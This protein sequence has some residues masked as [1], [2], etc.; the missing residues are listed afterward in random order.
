[1]KLLIMFLA[2]VGFAAA[3]ESWIKHLARCHNDNFALITEL[4]SEK[5]LK[6]KLTEFFNKIDILEEDP[7]Y[8]IYYRCG[9]VSSEHSIA[10]KDMVADFAKF[11]QIQGVKPSITE[12]IVYTE[13]MKDNYF[14]AKRIV[15]ELPRALREN[16]LLVY[17]QPKHNINS[18]KLAGGEALVRWNRHFK[19]FLFPDEMIEFEDLLK[20][21]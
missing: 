15:S 3:K 1:M 10:G 19:E 6:I 18:D 5:E 4:L 9:A 16:E 17:I 21:L 8:K 12:V 7:N 2:R 13:A 14:K 11:A 20:S